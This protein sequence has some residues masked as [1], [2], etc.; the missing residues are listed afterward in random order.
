MKLRKVLVTGAAGLIGSAITRLLIKDDINVIA[1]DNFSNGIWRQEDRCIDWIEGDIADSSFVTKLNDINAIDAVVHCAAHPGGRSI[2]EP[3]EDV[4]VNCLGSIHIFEW[5]ARNQVP[6]VFLSS[7]IVY[8]EQPPFPISESAPLKPGTV[9]AVCK[10]ACENFIKVLTNSYGLKFTILRLFATY[11]A[12]HLQSETQGIVNVMLTQL[13]KDKDI[14]VKG[15]LKRVRDLIYV[16]DAAKAVVACLK[17]E[18]T[19]GFVINVGTGIGITINEMIII[20]NELLGRKASDCEII[21]TSPTVGDPQYSVADIS[22]LKILTGFTPQY[23]IRDGF[24]L[25][26]HERIAVTDK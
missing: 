22:L 23:T 10:V 5:C 20:L 9:Y 16:E 21:E 3:C 15:S 2:A 26:V 18:K 25:F 13:L 7:S 12:G 17:E 4:R 6:V 11:G 24:G 14:I 8:G 1:C 19:R